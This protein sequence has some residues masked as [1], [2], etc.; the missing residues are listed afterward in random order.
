MVV[1]A[2]DCVNSYDQE[3]H[4]MS[5]RYMREHIASVMTNQEIV[6]ALTTRTG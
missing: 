2:A 5:L 4:E 1:L 6:S 3:H